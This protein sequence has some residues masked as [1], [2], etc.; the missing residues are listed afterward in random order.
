GRDQRHA[1]VDRLVGDFTSSL[2]LDVDLTEAATATARCG[3]LQDAFRGAA[4][5]SEYSGLEVLRDLSRHRG[6][7]VLAPVVFTSAL[8][9]GEL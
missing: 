8:G 9:L 1:D 5:H 7:Q 2:L 4:A 3:V 6:T